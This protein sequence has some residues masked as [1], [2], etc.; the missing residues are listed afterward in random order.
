MMWPQTQA[1]AWGGEP[2]ERQV[3]GAGLGSKLYPQEDEKAGCGHMG[4]H[5]HWSTRLMASHFLFS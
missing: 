3:N 4:W 5:R 1:D 2:A